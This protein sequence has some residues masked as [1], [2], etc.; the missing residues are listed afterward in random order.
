[1]TVPF[2]IQS[3]LV[4]M[5]A[6]AAIQ[7]ARRGPKANLGPFLFHTASAAL[8]VVAMATGWDE[9]N[10]LVLQGIFVVAPYVLVTGYRLGMERAM[11]GGDFNQALTMARSRAMLLPFRAHRRD[12]RVLEALVEATK[13]GRLDAE[14]LADGPG[15][16]LD[17]ADLALVADVVL[18]NELKRHALAHDW[19]SIRARRD[20]VAGIRAGILRGMALCLVA[21][22]DAEARDLEGALHAL[23]LLEAEPDWH[24]VR[25]HLRSAFMA[26]LA[27]GGRQRAVDMLLERHFAHLGAATRTAWRTRAAVAAGDRARAVAEIDRLLESGALEASVRE[28]LEAQKRHLPDSVPARGEEQ[29]AALDRIEGM[30]FLEPTLVGPIDR[31]LIGVPGVALLVTVVVAAFVAWHVILEPQVG[32]IGFAAFGGLWQAEPWR[33]VTATVLQDGPLDLVLNMAGVVV[34]G[35][36]VGGVYGRLNLWSLYLVAGLLAGIVAGAVTPERLVVTSSASVLG[37]AGAALAGVIRCRTYLPRTWM[38]VVGKR[39][40]VLAAALLLA[41]FFAPH[42]GFAVVGLV[43]GCGLGALLGLEGF[44]LGVPARVRE[45]VR[46]GAG[47]AAAG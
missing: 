8:V 16:A 47:A 13:Q 23:R 18:V 11:A 35:G 40:V 21:R 31:R 24:R 12:V 42:G 41:G 5:A 19:P 10:A 43:A 20:E 6:L 15:R 25:K 34:I 46:R 1:M 2:V 44:D 26:T 32:V 37:L 22:A 38:A 30:A 29:E 7:Y 4:V 39:V 45:K 14:T 3:M 9:P 28:A 27:V 36:A 33:F 17:E